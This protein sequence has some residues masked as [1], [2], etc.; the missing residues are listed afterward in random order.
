MDYQK[1]L[2]QFFENTHGQLEY[3]FVFPETSMNNIAQNEQ[4]SLYFMNNMQAM[5]DLFNYEYMK[6]LYLPYTS[7]NDENQVNNSKL[8][9]IENNSDHTSNRDDKDFRET[10][11][12]DIWF[13]KEEISQIYESHLLSNQET[14]HEP[15]NSDNFRNI[16]NIAS[17]SIS[18]DSNQNP[19]QSFEETKEPK[20]NFTQNKE[21]DEHL[22][23]TS[24]FQNKA[25]ESSIQE[26]DNITD[27]DMNKRKDVVFKTVLRKIRRFF[28]NDFMFYSTNMKIKRNN[29]IG[30]RRKI[31]N[32]ISKYINTTLSSSIVTTF[33]VFIWGDK[34]E[35]A[36]YQIDDQ[37]QKEEL[38]RMIRTVRWSLYKF[39]F[40]RLNELLELP[41]IW[42][43]IELAN[44]LQVQDSFD[45][46]EKLAFE[47]ILT[48][49]SAK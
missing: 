22:R 11:N 36:L 46:Y 26:N 37:S 49:C 9:S 21:S 12:K 14:N 41:W 3:K 30:L 38:E 23:T 39:N 19:K 16:E 13:R 24:D 27:I 28:R 17:K 47:M 35:K 29:I 25:N 43:I 1:Y 33:G 6:L 31:R 10:L 4:N 5:Q 8:V 7:A 34:I 20:Y 18:D 45:R 48:E 44:Q 15:R 40:K 42:E 2:D 32:Y